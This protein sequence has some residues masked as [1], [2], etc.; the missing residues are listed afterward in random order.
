MKLLD[1]RR[2]P[3][4]VVALEGARVV[5]LDGDE[6]YVE[7]APEGRHL[8]DNLAKPDNVRILREACRDVTGRDT[9]IRIVV[10]EAGAGG[11]AGVAPSSQ[12]DEERAERQRLRELA[13]NDPGVQKLLRTFR[14]EII[15]VRRIDGER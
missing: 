10:G 11:E 5:R 1:E 9:G 6:L 8:R 4:L 15:D 3:F 12:Q 13:E 7:Y 14:A 2:R